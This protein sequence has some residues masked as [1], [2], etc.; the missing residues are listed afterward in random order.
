MLNSLARL[1]LDFFHSTAPD[2]IVTLTRSDLRWQ[3]VVVAAAVLLLSIAAGSFAL[4][5][6]RFKT[7]E[8]TLLDFGA[9]CALYGVRMLI[10][11]SLF[12][13]EFDFSGAFWEHANW[14]ITAI[15]VLPIGMFAY[16]ILP[17]VARRVLGVLLIIQAVFG[18]GGIA[19]SFLGVNLSLLYH[20]NSILVLG[21]F[22]VLGVFFAWRRVTVPAAER[23]PV[24]RE[25]RV[26]LAGFL[27][28][29]AFI[30][31]ENLR[32]LGV[33]HG[34]PRSVEF[35]GFL[36]YVATLSYVT[37]FRT[38]ATE[39]R[40][41]AINTELEIARQIQTSTL[42]Q[43]VPE[44]AGLEIA[45]RYI[46]MSAVAGDFYDFLL[47]DKQRIGILI[48]D[49]TG[50]GVPAALIAA[51]LKVSFAAQTV[52]ADQPARVLD[53]LN[54][55]LCGKFEEYFVTAAY[56]YID[57]G[58]GRAEY[59]GA[60]HPALMHVSG[61]TGEVREYEENGLMLG[62]FPE[63]RY[64]AVEIP[65]APGDRCVLCTDGILEARTVAEE[66]YGKSRVAEVLR[67]QRAAS[68]AN[69]ADAVL[70]SVV[71]FSG[72]R[73]ERTQHDDMTLLVVDFK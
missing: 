73:A 28:W 53:G 31:F 10:N 62:M 72:Y 51:M 12:R 25:L 54:R 49:V 66:E 69:A 24:P 41:L 5:F 43:N 39:E 45:A 34:F 13:S 33:I 37:A 14:C 70:A 40:L 68:A 35:V 18:I 2:P 27:V 63:A 58:N 59:A 44:L 20:A 8:L 17:P 56:L 29:L 7:R 71:K 42:P 3:L 48:A 19:A 16:Q 55:A 1:S 64:A 57:L 4:F 22:V 61:A 23:M 50:H 46:P 67:T 47:I 21:S 60:A 52:H 30:I 65:I 15:I 6:A 9:F 32:G 26:L 38:F 11:V 36:I